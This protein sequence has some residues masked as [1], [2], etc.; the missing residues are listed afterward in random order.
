[1]GEPAH[2]EVRTDNQNLRNVVMAIDDP[3][4]FIVNYSPFTIVA[5]K[6]ANKEK[7]ERHQECANQ[8]HWPPA[9]LVDI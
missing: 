6:S 2:E 4:S 5:L 9:P 7:E 8:Q 3:H 1:M